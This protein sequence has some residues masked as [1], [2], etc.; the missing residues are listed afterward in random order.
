V[1]LARRAAYSSIA[2]RQCGS[3]RA[4]RTEE[5]TGEASDGVVVVSA[6]KISRSIGRRTPAARRVT[7]GW[8]CPGSRWMAT[9]WYNGGSGRSAGTSGAAGVADSRR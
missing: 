2:R 6:A 7:I 4:V 8:T 5:G 1:W 3:A 9:G